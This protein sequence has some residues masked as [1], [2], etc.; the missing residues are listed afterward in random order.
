MV[1]SEMAKTV[2]THHQKTVIADA[3]IAGSDKRRLV[4][5]IGGIDLTDG[6]W[7]TPEFPL[8]DYSATHGSDFYQGCTMGATSETGPRQPWQDIHAK[9]EGPAVLDIL[10]NFTER[11][12]KQAEDKIGHLVDFTE[13]EYDLEYVVDDGTC[14]WNTQIFR[15]CTSDSI[16]IDQ[17]KENTLTGKR[18]HLIDNSIFKAYVQSIRTAK[19]FIY[20][21]NQYF[22]GSAYSWNSNRDA[23]THHTLPREIVSKIVQSIESGQKFT[24]YIT[25]PMYPE[26]DPTS[27]ASQE[28]L[29]WQRRTM[30]SMY[31]RI[32][33]AIRMKGLDTKPTDYLMFFCLGKRETAEDVPDTLEDPPEDSPA[34]RARESIRHPVY[35]HSKLMI[36][37][38]DYIIVGSA[39]I[40]QRSMA[41]SRDSEIAMGAFQ[42]DFLADTEDIAKGDV[43]TFRLA[44]WSAHLGEYDPVFANPNSEECVDKVKEITK[45]FQQVYAADVMEEKCDV[46]M[47]EYPIQVNDDGS[48]EDHPDWVTFPDQGGDVAGKESKIF[49][50]NVT[51]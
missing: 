14:L 29:F 32:G 33:N 40:N 47:M 43:H 5:Y 34:S 4:G 8:F 31:F 46:H 3:E 49:P 26:G 27:M 22:L 48:V 9:I 16:V 2:Y 10:E 30:E 7:D 17:D 23:K 20:I 51:T 13:D 28:I 41:G 44:L 21:E 50:G 25:I 24:V 18:G 11:W 35:V 12:R 36:V 19:H 39:N 38:D 45:K 37:D 42:V 15:S 1:A 6:R